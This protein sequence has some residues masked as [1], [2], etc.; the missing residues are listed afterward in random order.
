MYRSFS[1]ILVAELVHGD[2]R[3]LGVR[4]TDVRIPVVF[5]NEVHI[6]EEET[7]PVLLLHGLPE[8]GVHQLGSVK[9]V[10][11]SLQKKN[12]NVSL[13]DRETSLNGIFV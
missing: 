6:M 3:V 9:G 2:G 13:R 10:V 12:K 4:V 11:S 7:V 8:T 5:W 1:D